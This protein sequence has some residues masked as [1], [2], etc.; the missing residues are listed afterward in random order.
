MVNPPL[1]RLISFVGVYYVC[2]T[3]T[4]VYGEKPLFCNI[5]WHMFCLFAR[6]RSGYPEGHV[7]AHSQS[8]LLPPK[9]RLPRRLCAV[10]RTHDTS[11]FLY[12]NTGRR[13]EINFELKWRLFPYTLTQKLEVPQNITPRLKSHMA[14]YTS[15]VYIENSIGPSTEL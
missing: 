13:H 8:E 9:T 12:F 1:G 7:H 2:T 6:G 11:S 5:T 15:A 4:M 10:N 3:Y 14:P